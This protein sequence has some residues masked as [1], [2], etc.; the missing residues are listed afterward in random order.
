MINNAQNIHYALRLE[1]DLVEFRFDGS[2]E[3]GFELIEPRAAIALNAVNLDV[4]RCLIKAGEKWEESPFAIDTAKET[5]TISF[6]RELQG[7]TGIKIDYAGVIN[8]R[9]AGFYRSQY[10]LDDRECYIAVTQFEESDAR[11][12][13]P[14]FDHPLKKAA[15]DLVLV[16]DRA[17]TAI[18]NGRL[19]EEQP[20]EGHKKAVRFERTP[21]MS[22]YLFFWGVGDFEFMEE[23]GKV[24]VRVAAVRG[25]AKHGA[26]GLAFGRKALEY[27]E[28][29]YGIEFPFKKLDLIAIP[30]FAFG[31]MENWAAITFRENLLLHYPGITSRSGEQRIC[32]V[33]AHETAHQWF[34]NLVSPS[35]WKYLWLN[36]SF[37]T[38]FGYGMVDHYFPEWGVWQ[39]FLNNQT[40]V[41]LNRDGLRETI[42]VEIPGGEHVVIN[43]STA[44]IIYNK[45]GSLLR[46]IKG[47]LGEEAFQQG[48]RRY[49]QK[50]AYACASSRDL[51]EAMEEVTDKPIIAIM[52]SWVNQPGH[53]VV[54]VERQGNRLR[55]SQRRFTYLPGQ[56]DQEWLIP[57]DIEFFD[58]QGHGRRTTFLMEGKSA[59]VALDPGAVVYKINTSQSGFFRVKYLDKENLNRLGEKISDRI[60][61]LPDRWGLQNDLYALV[62]ADD[63]PL[64]GYLD[65][66]D[67]YQ[68]ER[69][70]LPVVSMADNLF[71]AF[72]IVEGKIRDRV[73]A[74][75]RDLCER[76]LQDIGFDPEPGEGHTVSLVRD[77]LIWQG[78]AYG[79]RE[80]TETA[81]ARFSGLMKGRP[82]HADIVKGVMQAGALNGDMK[83]FRWFEQRLESSESEHERM[84]ILMSLG[85]F[86]DKALVA[87]A[88]EF[89]L[90]KVPA[91]NKF[92]PINALS[93]NPYS[94]SFLWEWY[95]KEREGLEQLHPLHYERIV[96]GIISTGGMGRQDEVK[97]FF[98][99]YRQKKGLA[100]ETISLSLERLEINT[101]MRSRQ[102]EKW[103]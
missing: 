3:L 12:A 81:L 14:C 46:Q 88:L 53:P 26:F 21:K 6:P 99:E 32:E 55:L 24:A 7:E 89:T 103:I 43:S 23:K 90:E 44:P 29:Y 69:D 96:S 11:Q 1:P 79:S 70:Y 54:E 64:A 13:F 34:G 40:D 78:A 22:T 73:M 77:Q 31:A 18:S 98:D 91:R 93:G 95:L 80:I 36:E 5:L 42:P 68:N 45:G 100:G 48:L 92:I 60:L 84:N 71:Q 2:V 76:V 67:Y 97:R 52:K 65:Y 82:L 62:R 17:L 58:G 50:H 9:L 51:W 75:G 57:L 30:D 94:A 86:R 37:A 59:T 15:F 28:D 8:D 39:Q 87:K 83:V 66:L 27:S 38:Y 47:Y 101:R 56:Y 25:R 16:I 72:G 10:R 61:S 49:L 102:K 35:D 85:G 33:I 19:L 63:F 20:V 74:A 4:R 41:A